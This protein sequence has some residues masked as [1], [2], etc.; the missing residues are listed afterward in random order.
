MNKFKIQSPHWIVLHCTPLHYF[1]PC[2]LHDEMMSMM[3]N[4]T[5]EWYSWR[6]QIDVFICNKHRILK[7]YRKFRLKAQNRTFSRCYVWWAWWKRRIFEKLHRK[8]LT[9][10]IQIQ[11]KCDRY[12]FHLWQVR[13]FLQDHVRIICKIYTNSK[14]LQFWSVL[15]RS[16][17]SNR[18]NRTEFFQFI[19]TSEER[20]DSN[21]FNI[22]LR[23]KVGASD[24]FLPMIKNM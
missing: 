6:H 1:I 20:C 13:K 10:T 16:K 3:R 19:Y 2:S 4:G 9:P 15:Q 24:I 21:T 11:C 7:M 22:I 14:Y 12:L 17:E 18:V 23:T 8:L 5:N